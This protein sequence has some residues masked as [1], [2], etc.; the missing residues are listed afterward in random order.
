MTQRNEYLF[1]KPVLL[2]SLILFFICYRNND[3]IISLWQV[4]TCNCIMHN[5]ET[6]LDQVLD[7]FAK[8]ACLQI[9]K[10]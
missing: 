1:L 5:I 2:R 10:N 9:D 7:Y 6:G 4:G 8:H 3:T